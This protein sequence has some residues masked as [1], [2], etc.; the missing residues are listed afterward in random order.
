MFF[1]STASL[2]LSDQDYQELQ[3]PLAVQVLLFCQGSQE[4]LEGQ[5]H[6]Y[7]LDMCLDQVGQEVL[8]GLGNLSWK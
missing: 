2:Y 3:G 6:L 4:S 1:I 7:L 8:D 5:S